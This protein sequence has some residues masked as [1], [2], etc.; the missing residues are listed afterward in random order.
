MQEIDKKI[1]KYLYYLKESSKL[2]L[3]KKALN[4]GL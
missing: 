4:K 1:E 3:M 2:D